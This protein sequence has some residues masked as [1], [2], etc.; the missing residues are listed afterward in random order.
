MEWKPT[1]RHQK[2]GE[3]MLVSDNAQMQ[4]HEWVFG[5]MQGGA[6]LTVDHERVRGS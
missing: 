6:G 3:Y 4:A 5:P 2:G 1:H